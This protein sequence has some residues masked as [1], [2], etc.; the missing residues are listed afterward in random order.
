M[1]KES[2]FIFV[3]VSIQKIVLGPQPDPFTL[4][5]GQKWGE[6][7]LAFVLIFEKLGEL[8]SKSAIPASAELILT[9]EVHSENVA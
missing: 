4:P 8:I 7:P 2:I 5:Q 1:N 6:G 9:G 3:E